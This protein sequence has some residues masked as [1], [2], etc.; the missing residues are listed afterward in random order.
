MVKGIKWVDEVVENAPYVTTLET[1]D[2]YDCGFCVHGSEYWWWKRSMVHSLALIKRWTSLSIQRHKSELPDVNELIITQIFFSF[3][4]RYYNECWWRWLLSSR[5][6]CWSIQVSHFQHLRNKFNIWNL[7]ILGKSNEHKAYQRQISSDE[8]C[9]WQRITSRK[10]TQNIQSHRMV[11]GGLWSS[12][13]LIG[14]SCFQ[15]SIL[16]NRFEF[17]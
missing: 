8:C 7:L 3:I 10:V 12:C 2:K 1:L 15:K 11:S 5:K 17:H 6:S 13:C 9:W 4:R 16:E 14:F